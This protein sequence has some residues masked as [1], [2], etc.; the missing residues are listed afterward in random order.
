MNV[1]VVFS[2]VANV[3]ANRKNRWGAVGGQN[4]EMTSQKFVCVSLYITAKV[5][6]SFERKLFFSIL[7]FAP[8]F[9]TYSINLNRHSLFSIN[10]TNQ[11]ETTFSNICKKLQL[12]N[13]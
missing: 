3:S 1:H 13:F 7:D 4:S 8:H 10:S 6:P 11:S 5:S 2:C 12:I 9:L